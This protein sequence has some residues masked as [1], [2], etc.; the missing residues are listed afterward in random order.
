MTDHPRRP[1]PTSNDSDI[2]TA[3]RAAVEAMRQD[4]VEAGI[5]ALKTILNLAP[6][7]EL[8][9]GMLASIYA[10]LGMR[11]AAVSKYQ[12]TLAINPANH[13][14]RFQ[15]GTLQLAL[16]D[17]FLPQLYAAI[18]LIALDRPQEA[19]HL[20]TLAQAAMPQDHPLRPLLAEQL[21]NTRASHD[22]QS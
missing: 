11:D 18:A 15:L 8:A 2:E 17:Q 1:N 5:L 22:Q 19:H 6:R 7:H 3:L 16:D 20:L 4:N 9:N 21:E 12:T 10:Q 14:A 13:L